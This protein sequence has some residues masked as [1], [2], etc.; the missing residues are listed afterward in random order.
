M[1]CLI[2]VMEARVRRDH[3][4]L[5]QIGILGRLGSDAGHKGCLQAECRLTLR[6][7]ELLMKSRI[8][9]LI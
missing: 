1:P 7:R 8:D 6:S 5:L 9:G 4:S 2:A 3:F